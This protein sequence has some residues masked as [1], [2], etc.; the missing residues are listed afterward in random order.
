MP[1]LN[2]HELLKSLPNPPHV[3]IT[4]ACSKY[5]LLG[6]ELAVTDYLLKPF[7]FESV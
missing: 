4:T 6:Y 5:A 7:S 3:I 2:G 1:E